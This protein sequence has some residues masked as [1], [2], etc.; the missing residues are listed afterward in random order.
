[1]CRNWPSTLLIEK[2][3]PNYAAGCKRL[4]PSNDWYPAL[5]RDNVELVTDGVEEVREHSIVTGAGEEHEVDAI[6]FGT[7][8]NVTDM[9]VARYV[10]GRAGKTLEEMTA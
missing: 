5:G 9:P 10:R 2:A 3:T 6:I 1:M 7:G 8:F 4:L